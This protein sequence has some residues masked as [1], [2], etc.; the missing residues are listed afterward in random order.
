LNEDQCTTTQA[1]QTLEDLREYWQQTMNAW[2]MVQWIK[3]GP[4]TEHSREWHIQFW[5]D[6]KNIIGRK[7]N[8][9]LKNPN[10]SSVDLDRAG[11][12]AQGLPALEYSLFDKKV[13]QITSKEQQCLLSLLIAE[14][15][16]LLTQSIYSDWL[17]YSSQQRRELHAIKDEANKKRVTTLVINSLVQ[18]LDVIVDKKIAKPFALGDS[19]ARNNPYFLESWRSQHSYENIKTNISAIKNVFEQGGLKYYLLSS[20]KI[21][22]ADA[23]QEKMNTIEATIQNTDAFY[24]STVVVDANIEKLKVEPLYQQLIELRHLVKIDLTKALN[25]RLG[26][27]SSDGDS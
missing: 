17:T 22:L 4:I 7:V 9:L 8:T 3:F 21:Q 15:M 27:N 24:F 25:I 23:I 13:E 14:K 10:L 11:I 18:Q 12:I 5:P 26:F 19:Q 2:Q 20:Q 16:L 6:T 1:E